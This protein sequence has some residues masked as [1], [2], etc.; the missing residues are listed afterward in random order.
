MVSGEDAR[1]ERDLDGSSRR[2]FLKT[3][4][5]TGVVAG[6]GGISAAQEAQE[7]ELGGET[8]GWVGQSP[9]EI[10]GETNP[11][12]E[13]EEGQSYV[14]TWENIDGLPH[15]FVLLDSEGQELEGTEITDG[16]G[17]TLTLEFEATAEM[18]EYY[19]SVHPNSM[20]GDIQLAGA[21]GGDQQTEET[22]RDVVTEGPTIGLEQIASGLTSPVGFEVAPDQEDRYY[23]VDQ[24]G[25]IRVLEAG[26]ETGT[27][28]GAESGNETKT[29]NETETCIEDGNE[30]KTDTEAG[31]ETKTDTEAGNETKTDT[32]AGNETKTDTE[33]GNE[34][35]TGT[36]GDA[37]TAGGT[38]EL[39]EEPFLDLT[40]RMVDVGEATDAG[41][42]ERGLLGL[43]FHPDFQENG[44]FF[45]RYSAPPTDDTPEDYD[46]TA[47]LS[48]FTTD[49]DDHAMG[50][51]DSEEVLLEVPEPQF[52][53]NA[54]AVLFGPDGY[55]Y[56]PLGDGGDADDTGLGH[57]EDWY[58]ENDGGNAQN[59]TENFLGS[60]L[61]LD[62]DAEGENGEPYGIPDDNPFVD[63][64]EGLGEYYAWGLRNP[65]RASFDSE[66]RFFVADVG[67]NLFE[68][69]NIVENG[70]NYGWNV[71]E[72]I[73][74]FSTDNPN[75]PGE[76]CPNSTPD[77][78]RGG[79]ELLDPVIHYPHQVGDETI[80]ISITGGYVYEGDTVSE[81]QDMY[82]Y[83]DWSNA[84]ETPG[85]RL[86]ASPV[87]E[88]EPTA[89]RS[90]E[91][92]WEIQ[93]LSVGG[94]ENGEINRFVLAFG[95]DH[96]GELYVLTTAR[97]TEGETGEVYRIVPEGDGEEIEE[98]EDAV[99]TED[100]T[101]ADGEA[102]DGEAEDEE[103]ETGDEA[104][105]E[106]GEEAAETEEEEA[107]ATGNETESETENATADDE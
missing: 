81:L 24:P 27:E 9:S 26:A 64:D 87:E 82:V 39:Q 36:G 107:N 16:E 99:G 103:A 17:E 1:R 37:D 8:S 80:G 52:N 85:G 70:G 100:E 21:E 95:R 79:E 83:G 54:G 7:F 44:R 53:H 69:V 43:A 77:D 19:C 55:L 32:E 62:V 34:T 63:S 30:T 25:Q 93:E 75:E 76:D 66:G 73:E 97:Y 88:Y 104:T 51:P 35:T 47:V 5:A 56:V 38:A 49:G 57:V 58:G 15:D 50:D 91:D 68:E 45:V 12:L 86:F 31:N 72:G 40:D 60:I 101:G 28:T 84:F 23:V 90:A 102:E 98:H 10:E 3:A 14:V 78:V 65:W 105:E 42:D 22:E 67:Q 2:L 92:L 29:E 4:A 74:C 6:L 106:G 46:H 48:E 13:L 41:F 61:R 18:A 71:K 96:D 33:A 94:S 89:D 59:T 11:T 20:R